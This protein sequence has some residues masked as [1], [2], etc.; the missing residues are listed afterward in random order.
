VRIKVKNA[1]KFVPSS[2]YHKEEEALKPIKTHYS[3]N[4]KPS[5]NPKIG[6]KKNTPNPS[7]EV[8]I[9]MFCGRVGHSDE[10]CF[11]CKRM[12]KWRVDYAR[13]P[14]HDEF[15]N[16]LPHIS[17]CA[18]SRFSHGPNHH[19]YAFGSQDNGLV[20]RCYGVDPWSHHGVHPQVGMVLPLEVSILTLSQVALMVHAFSIVVHVPLTQ[21]V[22]CKRL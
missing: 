2:N 5:F 13:N 7:E 14:Y 21:M 11:Q 3:S 12:D 22:R 6:V 16:F 17:S 18:P 15:I 8:Y 10:F 1:L 9:C 20:P 19:S 4:P